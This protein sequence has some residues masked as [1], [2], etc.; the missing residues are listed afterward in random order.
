MTSSI[1]LQYFDR[2][3][4]RRPHREGHDILKIS[5]NYF[6][7]DE[8]RPNCLGDIGTAG[9]RDPIETIA[10]RAIDSGVRQAIAGGLYRARQNL[11]GRAIAVV[12]GNRN[13]SPEIR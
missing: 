7:A 13:R 9:G 2:H 10:G 5:S 3:N 4:V 6:S 8:G 1:R 11:E 12:R